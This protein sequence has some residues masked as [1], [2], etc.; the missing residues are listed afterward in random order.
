[1]SAN[2]ERHNL[3]RWVVVMAIVLTCGLL[4]TTYGGKLIQ[5]PHDLL[6]SKYV[7]ANGNVIRKSYTLVRESPIG[8]GGIS[9]YVVSIKRD[10]NSGPLHLWERLLLIRR[11]PLNEI[12][13]ENYGCVYNKY[14]H[15]LSR[16]R[17]KTFFADAKSKETIEQQQMAAKYAQA[18]AEANP[19]LD[20]S[21]NDFMLEDMRGAWD[22]RLFG[23]E[24][25]DIGPLRGFPNLRELVLANCEVADLAVL[26]SFPELEYLILYNVP[27]VTDI[28]A[29]ASLSKL[30]FLVLWNTDVTDLRPLQNLSKLNIVNLTGNKHLTDIAPLAGRCHDM[31]SVFLEAT[32][33][34]DVSPLAQC[35]NL[36]NVNLDGTP[37]EDISSLPSNVRY[38]T[39][40]N[41]EVRDI[42]RLGALPRLTAFYFYNT[43]AY[44]RQLTCYVVIPG[45]L[46]ISAAAAIA[47]RKLR[48][49]S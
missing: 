15:L 19:G 24:L 16:L 5:R 37:V 42:S 27:K 39:V 14:S 11:L 40:A 12:M 20:V 25:H 34:K 7:D 9:H 1:M 41:S 13:A 30:S 48:P 3:I 44:W 38:L 47:I 18:L 21:K 17:F 31:V 29:L 36:L 4:A 8:P 10:R 33:V 45:L 35:H 2:H 26:S 6:H 22:I 28:S 32:K 46:V 49:R 43:P 23:R